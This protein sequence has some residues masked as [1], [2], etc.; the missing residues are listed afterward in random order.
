MVGIS[1]DRDGNSFRA[2]LL[3]HIRLRLS[4]T[5]LEENPLPPTRENAILLIN[6][7]RTWQKTLLFF[8]WIKNQNLFPMEIIF[9]NVTMKSL[10]FGRQFQLVENL[11][12]EMID[13]GVEL[14]NITYS[15]IFTCAK[16][17]NLFD[18][19]LEWF[20]RMY[21]T[22]LMPNGV[23]YSAILDVYANLGKVK[24]V[25][26][27]YARGRASGWKPD[28]NAFGVLGK[29]FGE[30]GDYDGIKYVLEEMNSLGLKPNL[31][32]YSTL[33]DAFGKAKKPAVA[34]RL[35]EEMLKSDI[36]PDKRTLTAL[37]KTYG[38]ERWGEDALEL[39]WRIKSKGWPMDFILYNI[40]L[41][42]CADLGLEEEAEGIFEDMKGSANLK[43]DSWSYTAMLNIYLCKWG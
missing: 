27:L 29:M 4:T 13:H 16:R 21:E 23:T 14:D 1:P 25:M 37:C 12:F 6:S 33:I 34:P 36:E 39:W 17:C 26:S 3:P 9:Y 41:S 20:E 38:K 28:S 40:L 2:Y 43:P 32:F 10:R 5:I 30:F 7:L 31:I 11:A 24:E 15:I 19:A 22:G 8:N 35:F 42:M 18:K